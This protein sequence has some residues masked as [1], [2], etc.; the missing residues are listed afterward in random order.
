M[1]RL[2]LSLPIRI[3]LFLAFGSILFMSV[4]LLSVGIYTIRKVIHFNDLTQNVDAINVSALIMS[5]EL[6]EFS[7][8]GFKYEQFYTEGNSE[9]LSR[10]SAQYQFLANNIN[11]LASN[12]YF[13]NLENRELLERIN[14]L[15]HLYNKSKIEL[16]GAFDKRGF[17]DYGIEGELRSAI[18][19]V[20][21][22]NFPYDKVTMLMLRRHEK[23]FFLRKNLK[24]LEKFNKEIEQFQSDI[25]QKSDTYGH[26]QIK[27]Y[28][29]NYAV[30]FAQ[31]VEMEQ[32]IGLNENS[33]IRGKVRDNFNALNQSLV[34]LSEKIKKDKD[35]TVQIAM[36]LLVSLLAGQMIVGGILIFFYA[37]L[38]SNAI[39]D[40]KTVLVTLSEGSFPERMLIRTRDEI[41]AA[42]S[43]LNELV[44]RIKASVNFANEIGNGNLDISY[45]TNY[46]DDVL[47]KS[48]IKMQHELQDAAAK[49]KDLNWLN[50]GLAEFTT[51]LKND[52]DNIEDLGDK[53]IAT[54][55][56]YL[57]A[58]QGSIYIREE[59][60]LKSIS[61]YAYSKK[62]FVDSEFEIGQGLAGQCALEKD[63]IL[64]TDI[65]KDYVKITSGL[66]EATPT[67]ILIM[68]LIENDE[69]MGV[70][71][72]ASFS[73][74]GVLQIEYMSKVCENIAVI[75]SS[76]KTAEQTLKLL[77]E[78]E[79]KG[80]TLSAHEEELRQNAEELQATQEEMSRQKQELEQT[81][82]H[83]KKELALKN[84]IIANSSDSYNFNLNKS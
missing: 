67:S 83:L 43:A 12:N 65:P 56:N 45:D 40:I 75:I 64:M 46:K 14:G 69:V 16:I 63:Y 84:E 3:K 19:D 82:I 41:G 58:N 71:E 22:S 79:E 54:I 20:E 39:K 1:K 77:A 78:S 70:I 52:A 59:N 31:I 72:L 42:K 68:P 38:L 74:F 48:I 80:A 73:E 49:Q 17:Q 55:V 18:H 47:A 2:F 51:I 30:L 66:G 81:V 34:I 6:K 33:G 37:N 36:V 23:D 15:L 5:A 21:D 61:T 28:I 7:N 13:E 11:D 27:A 10:Y 53:M 24:Y 4:L 32:L 25:I 29:N 62:K 60:R 9:N 57:A 76:K 44:S 8:N 35:E 26:D 50:E